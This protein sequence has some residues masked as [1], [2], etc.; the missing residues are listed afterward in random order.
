MKKIL[1]FVSFL[2]IVANMSSANEQVIISGHFARPPIDWQEEEKIVGAGIEILE[3]IFQE[4]GIEVESRYVGP[5]KRVLVNLED[6]EIDVM[7]GLYLTEERK[8][9]A[10]FTE[11]FSDDNVTIFVWHDRAFPFETWDDLQG[12]I[13]GD[14]LGASRGQEFE[15]WREQHNAKIEY[16]SDNLL[17]LKKLEVGRIDCFIASYYLG[18]MYIRKHGY[19]GKIIPLKKPVSTQQL[20]Y[21]F[22]KKSPFVKYL[23]QINQHIQKMR[24]NGRVEAIFQK[25][26]KNYIDIF[27]KE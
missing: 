19:E 8:E 7:C 14:I 24:E 20:R 4:L 17:N 5:W 11:P 22:S 9:F 18:I 15:K 23:P 26:L 10:E 13:F 16:V 21:A 2:V 12:K 1:F 27:F 3:M 25:H 6:G